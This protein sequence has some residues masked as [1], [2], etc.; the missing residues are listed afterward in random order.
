MDVIITAIFVG[1]L[2]IL[3]ALVRWCAISIKTEE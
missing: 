2:F 1:S 3:Y